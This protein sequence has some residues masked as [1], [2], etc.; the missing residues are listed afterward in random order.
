MG[1]ALPAA[2]AASL[3]HRDR[4]VVALAGDGGFAMTMA[5]LET[6]V[7]ARANVI[8]LV[9]DNER[10]GTIRMHQDRRGDPEPAAT[11]L[12]AID[13]AAVAR[14]FGATGVRVDS[15]VELEPALRDAL[16]GDGPA[17][18]QLMVDRRWV[19]VDSGSE[20]SD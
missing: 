17:V 8:A 18:I 16:A 6:A 19:S 11:D 3:V 1:Y 7:R 12:G 9:F 4:P 5:E 20:S 2:I 15:D 10:Y 14:G 13:F